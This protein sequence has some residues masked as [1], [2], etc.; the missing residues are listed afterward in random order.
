[1]CHKKLHQA[2][3][4]NDPDYVFLVSKER[5]S[6]LKDQLTELNIEYEI[7]KCE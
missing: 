1:M 4:D 3:V 2:D 6:L 7:L 5:G